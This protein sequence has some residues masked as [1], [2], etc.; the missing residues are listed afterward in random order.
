MLHIVI[1]HTVLTL[2]NRN[3]IATNLIVICRPPTLTDRCEDAELIVIP[4]TE[5]QT[6]I[7][8]TNI[9][10]TKHCLLL[11]RKLLGFVPSLPSKT[12]HCVCIYIPNSFSNNCRSRRVGLIQCLP[13]ATQMEENRSLLIPPNLCVPSQSS[14]K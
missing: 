12:V 5:Q 4:F 11:E 2:R 3:C 8:F 13:H 10:D 7:F 9:K 6:T 14:P 1:S